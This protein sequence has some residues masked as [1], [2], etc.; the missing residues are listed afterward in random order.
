MKFNTFFIRKNEPLQLSME[1]SRSISISGNN[2]LSWD[3]IDN[4]TKDLHLKGRSQYFQRLAE[5][6][7]YPEIVEKERMKKRE[8]VIY[9]LI[10]L[11]F[12]ALVLQIVGVL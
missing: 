6:D 9:S 7:I 5:Q 12:F 3:I 8:I 10:I 1:E 2:R 4:R 11:I